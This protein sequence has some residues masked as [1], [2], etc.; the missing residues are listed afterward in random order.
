MKKTLLAILLSTCIL[1]LSISCSRPKKESSFKE[2]EIK[3][4]DGTVRSGAIFISKGY[5]PGSRL[6]VIYMADGLVFKDGNYKHIIDSL[7]D[8]KCISPIVVACSYEDKRPIPGYTI[9][10]R[11]AEY[12]ESLSRQDPKLAQLFDNHYEYFVNEFIPYV[13]RHAPVSDAKEEMLFYG[14]SN[15]AD[16]GLT[17]S[18]RNP[19]LFAEYWCYSPVFS[20]LTHYGMLTNDIDYRICWGIK[21]EIDSDDYFPTLVKDIRKRGGNVTSWA[22]NGVH[23]RNKWKA[24]FR[25]EL[26]R[27]FP[28][29]D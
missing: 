19:D 22:F 11:N 1:S 13:R 28:Y 26:Q 23:D 20:D 3:C 12:V 7:I 17:L 5:K 16:F 18:M 21:E 2:F 29:K 25:E 6:P 9:A 4:H 15:S 14:T 27:R 8:E 24:N 10:Y